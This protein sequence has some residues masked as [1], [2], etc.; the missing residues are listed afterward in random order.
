LA[1][2]NFFGRPING[3]SRIKDHIELFTK[4]IDRTSYMFSKT[5]ILDD[6]GYSYIEQPQFITN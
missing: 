5:R 3:S 4:D 6:N 1:F 2:A